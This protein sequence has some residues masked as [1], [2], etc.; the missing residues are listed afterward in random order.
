MGFQLSSSGGAARKTTNGR[1]GSRRP[2][3]GPRPAATDR[4]GRTCPAAGAVGPWPGGGNRLRRPTSRELSDV[5]Y[6]RAHDR[7]H[8]SPARPTRPLGRT[9]SSLWTPSGEH[10]VDRPGGSGPAAADAPPTAPPSAPRIGRWAAAARSRPATCRP[11]SGRAA[12]E[13]AR[14]IDEAR[15]QLLELRPPARSSGSRPCSS[16]SWRPCTCPSPS[17][18]S[19]TPGSPST[20]WPP[21]SSA[22]APGWAR[23]RPRCARPL[24]QLQLAYVEVAE[25]Q[26]A[27][28]AT[29]PRADRAVP[30][31]GRGRPGT[32]RNR[33]AGA[34]RDR[35]GAVG[36]GGAVERQV[37]A[38]VGADHAESPR[39]VEVPPPR[40]RPR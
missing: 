17:P 24:N 29:R 32:T 22:S 10:P 39:V 11:R 21:W 4:P 12:E 37:A 15:R 23:P 27:G 13:Y 34:D 33:T 28:P 1:R 14:Q 6:Q 18:A 31:H 5:G 26:R 7:P 9:M 19:R 36:D 35:P 38:A 16:T 20:P 8:P 40:P 2:R 3:R 25:A 30:A